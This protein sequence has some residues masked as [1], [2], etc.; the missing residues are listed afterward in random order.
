MK[1]IRM[2]DDYINDKKYS[3][4]YKDNGLDIINYTKII[5]FSSSL[6]SIKYDDKIYYIEAV[7][8]F[9]FV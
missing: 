1:L 7:T 8:V 6:I 2:V 9:P 4:I 5:D 3:M